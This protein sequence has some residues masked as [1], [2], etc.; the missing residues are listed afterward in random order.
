M[1]GKRQSGVGTASAADRQDALLLGVEVYQDPT[2]EHI[3]GQRRGTGEAR[4][5]IHREEQF[6]RAVNEPAGLGDGEHRRDTDAVVGAE[7]R[8]RRLQVLAVDLGLDGVLVEIVVDVGILL[9]DHVEMAL[10]DHGV[11]AFVARRGG[12]P[13]HHVAGRVDLVL[14]TVPLGDAEDVAPHPP[15]R[16]RSRGG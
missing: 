11:S 13:D 12:L 8:A 16:C 6:E 15:P 10:E 1:R 5:L 3:V 7:R 9:V 14:Q 2:L 4:L